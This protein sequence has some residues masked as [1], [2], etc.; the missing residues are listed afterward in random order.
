MISYNNSVNADGDSMM[1]SEII[2]I[3]NFAEEPA[4][5]KSIRLKSP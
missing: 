5:N 2:E 3:R 4:H 1:A